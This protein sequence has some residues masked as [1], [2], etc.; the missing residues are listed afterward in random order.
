MPEEQYLILTLQ[1]TVTRGFPVFLLKED[2]RMG[3]NQCSY[4]DLPGNSVCRSERIFAFYV[5]ESVRNTNIYFCC[6]N[7]KRGLNIYI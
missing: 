4:I 5:F 6:G 1:S 7:T 2:L 3:I